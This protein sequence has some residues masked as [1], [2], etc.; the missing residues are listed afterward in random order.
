MGTSPFT[1]ETCGKAFKRSGK[2]RHHMKLH[3]KYGPPLP[4]P[5][6]VQTSPSPVTSFTRSKT[7]LT[8]FLAPNILASSSSMD[9][10]S[11]DLGSRSPPTA[12]GIIVP[13]TKTSPSTSSAPALPAR[14]PAVEV[15]NINPGC[16]PGTATGPSSPANDCHLLGAAVTVTCLS[17]CDCNQRL[18]FLYLPLSRRLVLNLL[19]SRLLRCLKLLAPVLPMRSR[20][21]LPTSSR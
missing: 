18:P 1:C 16:S 5:P 10:Y 20:M 3:I 11:S 17:F 19:L 4:R 8:H 6:P 14:S 2:L 13:T 21:D 7:T 15:P 9:T 12:P